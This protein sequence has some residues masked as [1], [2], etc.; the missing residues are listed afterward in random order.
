MLVPVIQ[1]KT[2]IGLFANL[3][4]NPGLNHILVDLH[5]KCCRSRSHKRVAAAKKKSKNKRVGNAVDGDYVKGHPPSGC[6]LSVN[7]L[8]L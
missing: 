2:R 1:A 3:H 8:V 6:I 7:S 5:S 4:L